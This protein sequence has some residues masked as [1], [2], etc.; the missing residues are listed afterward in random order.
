MI[1]NLSVF[2][3]AYN[4]E[5]NIVNTISNALKVLKS[6]SLENYELI[7]VDDG[8]SDKTAEKVS[9]IASK[10]K[11]V[12][13]ISHPKNLGYGSALKTGFKNAKYE[14]VAF[15][16]SDGQ[17]DFAEIKL[18]L[19]KTDQADLVLGYRLNRADPFMRKVFTFGWSL[20]ARILLGLDT[21]DYSCGFK[22]IKKNVF[23]KVQ[24]LEGEEKVTQI[25]FLVKAKRLGFKFA[26]V[27]VH[28]YPRKFGV[29]T[30]A[31]LSVVIKSI[32]DLF[33]LWWQIKEQ[34]W[35]FFVLL[36]IL[37]LAA[38][39]RFYNLPGYMT[40][41]GDEGRDALMIKRILITGDIPLLG[42]PTSIGNMYLGPLYYYMMSVP[43]SIFYL[44]PVAAAG[45]VALIGT[46]TVAL[47]YYLGK[48]WF[49]RL[50]GLLSAFLYAISPVNII[51]SRSSWNPNPAPFFTLLF[52]FSFYQ[53]YKRGNFLWLILTGVSLAFA[54]QMHYLA[55]ILVPIAV[56][57]YFRQIISGKRKNV[58][59]GTV[60]GVLVSLILMSPLV[61]FDLKHN[62]MN[63]RA[64]TTFFSNRET[65]VNLNP[66]NTLGRVVPIYKDNLV[67]RY[68]TTSDPTVTPIVAVLIILTLI[69]GARK[70][71]AI[72]TLGIWLLVGVLGL[73]LYK[74]N[75]YDHYL[76]FLN[77][78][79]YLLLGGSLV[80]F[81]K[82]IWFL[83]IFLLVIYLAYL[84]L[85]KNPLKDPPQ[86]QL[87]R[88]Q[89]ISRFVIKA[90]E[91]KPFNFAL[92]A[93][94]NYDA[95]YQFY[96]GL[97]GYKPKQVP[98]DIT[99]QLFVVCEDELCDPPT[100]PKQEISHFGM[101][102]VEWV[103]EVRGI[104]V[105]KLI[106]SPAK[107]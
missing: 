61:I 21:K 78:A 45:M 102:N 49:G 72:Q 17:F 81:R 7:I 23:D 86:N 57:L 74:Q 92:I 89:E 101:T 16:D 80:L 38:Y 93:K 79:P 9:Q 63:Y 60:L 51:Y 75:I 83:I 35:T 43:M 31:K 29:P 39:L 98:F 2:F 54:V 41:L 94:S 85:S 62:L 87:D 5:G 48:S 22:L 25:E 15:A 105:Y 13:L 59:S 91:E 30:G 70:N 97:Y 84:N 6:L 4:E 53:I 26:E 90:S 40:F 36:L 3:P 69:Y 10:E 37:A 73:A 103:K 77:P 27:G 52:I 68:M 64:V 104:K 18:L 100:N 65:T 24:P 76:G 107:P 1:K 99:D 71:W 32:F 28:H 67:G 58:L 95:A 20:A 88:T 50:S 11:E 82:K 66:I 12:V 14:W 47:V 96:L 34:R 19:D 106:H 42:P 46:L 44:N 8:S 55:L 56:I 33:K